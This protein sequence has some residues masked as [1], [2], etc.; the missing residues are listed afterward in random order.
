MTRYRFLGTETSDL[1]THFSTHTHTHEPLVFIFTWADP[2]GFIILNIIKVENVPNNCFF[3]HCSRINW[4]L[5]I[6]LITTMS[7]VLAEYLRRNVLPAEHHVAPDLPCV[8]HPN[9]HLKALTEPNGPARS[10]WERFSLTHNQSE[11]RFHLLPFRSACLV[12]R[13]VQSGQS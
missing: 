13:P 2:D 1:L 4:T 7:F 5:V 3:S 9:S 11:T 10:R 12:V 6:L 8:L